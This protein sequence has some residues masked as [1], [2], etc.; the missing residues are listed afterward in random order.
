MYCEDALGNQTQLAVFIHDPDG[1]ELLWL[2]RKLDL[3]LRQYLTSPGF[4]E[5][6]HQTL[7]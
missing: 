7:K 5:E 2:N 6:V 1:M 3:F 4:R